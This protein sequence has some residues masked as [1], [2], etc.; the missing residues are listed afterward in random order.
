MRKYNSWCKLNKTNEKIGPRV[1]YQFST[2]FLLKHTR[3]F[4]YRNTNNKT[5]SVNSR[6]WTSKMSSSTVEFLGVGRCRK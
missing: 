1:P 6:L 4:V 5:S 3:T 2:D